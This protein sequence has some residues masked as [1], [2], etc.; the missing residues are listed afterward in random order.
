MIQTDRDA[1]LYFSQ[2]IEGALQR[3]KVEVSP[4]TEVYLTEMLTHFCEDFGAFEDTWLTP[5]TF[6][7]Q[8]LIEETNRLQQRQK[9]QELGDHCLFLVGYFYPFVAKSGKG[10]VQYHLDMGAQAYQQAGSKP[11]PELA[12]KFDELY[13][14]IGDLHLPELDEIKVLQI[15]EK[16]LQ[17]GDK[18]YESLLLGKGIIPQRAKG[19]KN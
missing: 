5:I 15:Y 4:E 19:S 1:R 3:H 7:Y 13:L 9:Q 10:Q 12:Q 18:Y 16:W 2:S 8:H 11:Y 6:Q 14:V 17:S